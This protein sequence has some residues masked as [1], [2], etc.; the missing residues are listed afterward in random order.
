MTDIFTNCRNKFD[1][2]K[3]EFLGLLDPTIGLDE[4]I[5]MSFV[6]HFHTVL[7]K[8]RKHQLCPILK[9]LLLQIIFSITT[10]SLLIIFLKYSQEL[11]GFCGFDVVSDASKFTLFKQD[12][13]A[14]LQA[15]FDRLVNLP[16]SICQHIDADKASMALFDTPGIKTWV[17][18]NNPKYANRIIRQLKTFKGAHNP[19]DSYVPYKT[20]YGSMPSHTATNPAIQQTYINGTYAMPLNSASLPTDLVLSGI[21]LS[22]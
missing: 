8:P 19:D 15:I 20:A 9:A 11:Q 1:N 13:L 4:I 22:T 14:D 18:E 16:K 5:P 6:S 12:F 17:T 7:G 3:Y 10:V 2:D 21:L